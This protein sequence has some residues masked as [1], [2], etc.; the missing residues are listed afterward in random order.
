MMTARIARGSR[1]SWT[2]VAIG[3]ASALNRADNAS[4][5][6]IGAGPIINDAAKIAVVTNINAAASQNTRPPPRPSVESLR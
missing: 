5:A 1:I 4:D 2:T 6:A 3:L